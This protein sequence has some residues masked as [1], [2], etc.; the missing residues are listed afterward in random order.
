MT[1]LNNIELNINKY[2]I[3]E[4]EQILNLEDDYTKQDVADIVSN[5]ISNFK[6]TENS[7]EINMFFN[8]IANRLIQNIHDKEYAYEHLNTNIEKLNTPFNVQNALEGFHNMNLH[9][10]NVDDIHGIGNG[11]E[12]GIRGGR[13]TR[14]EGIESEDDYNAEIDTNITVQNDNRYANSDFIIKTNKEV[15]ETIQ[16]SL[17]SDFRR[18]QFQ[19]TTEITSTSNFTIDLA[20]TINDVISMELVSCEIPLLDYNFSATKFNNKFKVVIIDVVNSISEENIIE[21]PEGIWYA[22][23]LISY[24]TTYYLGELKTDAFSNA[25]NYY[26]RYLVVEFNPYR[27]NIQFRLKSQTELEAHNINYGVGSI[28]VNLDY[29]NFTYVLSNVYSEFNDIYDFHDTCLGTLGFGFNDIYNGTSLRTI[30]V[31]DTKYYG[32]ELYQGVCEGSLVFNSNTNSSLYVSVD[33]YQQHQSNH[34]LAVTSDGFVPENVISKVQLTSAVF[35]TNV[36]NDK[37]STNTVRK[38]YSPVRIFRLTIKILN[39]FGNIVDLKNYPTSFVFELT[40]KKT[41]KI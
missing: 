37:I 27:G 7:N 29:T 39:K 5:H 6:N 9:I 38:Y 23:R 10:A 17:T 1:S 13:D 32:L 4:L 40:K 41:D 36:T 25:I 19:G 15:Y 12:N 18:K 30:T 33:D 35:S 24:I 8:E 31:N 3:E 21:I 2:T 20:D 11:S 26:L 34:F 14:G 28:D 16:V 22:S